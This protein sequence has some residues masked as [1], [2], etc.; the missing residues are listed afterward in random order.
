MAEFYF[1]TTNL[2]NMIFFRS[3]LVVYRIQSKYD[4]ECPQPF[5]FASLIAYEIVPWNLPAKDRKRGT[6]PLVPDSLQSL[7]AFRRTLLIKKFIILIFFPDFS[8]FQKLSST[9]TNLYFRSLCFL[10]YSRNMGQKTATIIK[11]KKSIYIK[12]SNLE[13]MKEILLPEGVYEC[14]TGSYKIDVFV[15]VP[16]KPSYQTVHCQT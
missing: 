11:R 16:R 3:H 4:S 2:R 7:R 12:F 14:W 8:A 9:G 5:R 13:L 10:A 1:F 15:R 6:V